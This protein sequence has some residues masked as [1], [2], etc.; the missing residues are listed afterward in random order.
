MTYLAIK[1]RMKRSK[2]PRTA[3]ILSFEYIVEKTR[4]FFSL[5]TVMR[6]SATDASAKD[7]VENELV[8]KTDAYKNN[9]I[10]YLNGEYWYLSGGGLLSMKEMIEEVEAG[11]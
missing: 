4:T 9:K 6:Q 1:R 3:K 2:F 8:K 10:I 11:L 5:S 7:S